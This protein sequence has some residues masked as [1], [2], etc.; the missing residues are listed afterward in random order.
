MVFLSVKEKFLMLFR[1]NVIRNE[2]DFFF[3]EGY[4]FDKV[5]IWKNCYYWY[6]KFLICN[7][8]MYYK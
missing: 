1:Y 2:D 8:Y 6:V 5:N 7:F 4:Y 3:F